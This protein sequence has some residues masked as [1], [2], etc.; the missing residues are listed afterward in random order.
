[1]FIYARN[2]KTQQQPIRD[3]TWISQC[4]VTSSVCNFSCQRNLSQELSVGRK[5]RDVRL[6][7]SQCKRKHWNIIARCSTW[8]WFCPFFG[9]ATAVGGFQERCT[10]ESM[11]CSLL[12]E[13]WYLVNH[14]VMSARFMKELHWVKETNPTALTGQEKVRYGSIKLSKSFVHR[15]RTD[16]RINKETVIQW[17]QAKRV[18]SQIRVDW[19]R[20]K[21]LFIVKKTENHRGGG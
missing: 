11:L 8:C 21:T 9:L 4:S 16:Y 5:K 20:L 3:A 14:S 13:R 15:R 12:W 10:T 17:I 1:M 7:W 2:F 6:L 18:R 19:Q